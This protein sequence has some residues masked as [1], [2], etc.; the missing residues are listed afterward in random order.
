MIKKMIFGGVVLCTLCNVSIAQNKKNSKDQKPATSTKSDVMKKTP[1]G[2]EYSFFKDD[3]NPKTIQ[4]G[5]VVKMHIRTVISDSVM[6]DTY[7]MN[8]NE[9]IEQPM[10]KQFIGAF[11]E[12][13]T[14]CGPG[15]SV[16][17]QLP[18]DSAFKDAGGLPPFAKSGDKVKWYLKIFS[19]KSKEEAEADRVK[20]SKSQ[21]EIDDKLIRE[22]IKEKNLKTLKTASGIYYVIDKT[23]NGP[24]FRHA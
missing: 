4:E 8:N 19:V 15:D 16:M 1:S 6:F 24:A 9:P 21:N 20:A 22:Y 12:G 5:S 2:V 7:K 18:I 3:P 17:L 10:S 11:W 14:M 23:G 13:F